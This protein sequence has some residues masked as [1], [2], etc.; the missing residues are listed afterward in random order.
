MNIRHLTIFCILVLITR[1]VLADAQ[2]RYTLIQPGNINIGN[3]SFY[4]PGYWS[5]NRVNSTLSWTKDGI[6]LNEIVFGQ[7]HPG[8]H[9]LNQS[10]KQSS[11]F[12]YDP[13]MTMNLIVEQFNDAL[14]ISNYHNVTLNDRI[15]TT[16]SNLPAIRFKISYDTNAGVNY[17]AWVLFIK[18]EN[19]LLTLFCSATTRHYFPMLENSFVEIIESVKIL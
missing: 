15:N 7:I 9:V 19:K 2:T 16:I 17:S 10:N 14:S 11:N 18:A 13:T 8:Q 3:F 5:Q 4:N 6:L 12:G 1:L